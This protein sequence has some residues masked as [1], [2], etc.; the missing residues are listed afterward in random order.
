MSG[1]H[2]NLKAEEALNLEVKSVIPLPEPK[3][4]N[5]ERVLHLPIVASRA[6]QKSL[7]FV[8]LAKR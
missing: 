1:V 7:F 5:I 8:G 6:A 3:S 2:V 4:V